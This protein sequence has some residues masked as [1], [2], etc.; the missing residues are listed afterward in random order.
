M[1]ESPIHSAYH[2]R[3]LRRRVSTYWWLERRSYVAF[4]LREVSS[5][6]IAWFVLFLLLLVRA[7]GAGE[8][9]YTQFLAWAATPWIVLLN[10]VSLLFVIFH[11]V[12]WFNL[13]PA[14]MVVHMRGRRVPGAVIAGSNYVAAIVAS[15]VVAW[16]LLRG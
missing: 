6:F 2:P 10:V 5:V 4:I 9:A 3:W 15:A 13:A 11:A 14:A 1:L 16:L 7:V 12:T 8:G